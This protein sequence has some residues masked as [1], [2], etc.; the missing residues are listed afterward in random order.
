MKVEDTDVQEVE[1]VLRVKRQC[2]WLEVGKPYATWNNVQIEPFLQCPPVPF[3]H[4]LLT[5]NGMTLIERQTWDG[6]PTGIYDVYDIIGR[7]MY[8][9]SDFIEE[10]IR[11]GFSRKYN[12]MHLAK[13]SIESRH[14]FL[15]SDA[16]IDNYKKL[17][18]MRVGIRSCPAKIKTHDVYDPTA[19]TEGCIALHWETIGEAGF[20]S[21]SGGRMGVKHINSC[22]YACA[23]APSGWRMNGRLGII[24]Y[25]PFSKDIL[26]TGTFNMNV[27]HD[28]LGASHQE[29]M[30]L[31]ANAGGGLP[32]QLI[33][34]QGDEDEN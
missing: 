11:Y 9:L 31:L 14:F 5:D 3:D 16:I 10:G 23:R 2:G 25:L 17:A 13:L 27:V 8:S 19:T 34:L 4:A 32:Y 12:P 26:R 7:T 1:R 6:Q 29:A 30:E 20:W 15:I 22:T 28:P 24:M 18:S 33:T 21:D